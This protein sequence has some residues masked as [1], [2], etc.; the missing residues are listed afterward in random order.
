M[1][2]SVNLVE[3]AEPYMQP[4]LCQLSLYTIHQAL[5]AARHCTRSIASSP[6]ENQ[7]GTHYS[8]VPPDTLEPLTLKKEPSWDVPA[9]ENC[10]HVLIP[11]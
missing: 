1:F 5:R 10:L 11:V 8:S 4:A 2:P 3:S 6:R 7:T 9:G